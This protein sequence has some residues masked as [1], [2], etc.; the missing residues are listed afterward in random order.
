MSDEAQ[1]PP[2]PTPDEVEAD[3]LLQR[4]LAMSPSDAVSVLSY[5]F[6]RRDQDRRY[7][8]LRALI[9]YATE[10]AYEDGYDDGFAE[11]GAAAGEP[12]DEREV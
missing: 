11:G 5:L 6:R 8:E 7:P 12:W 4:F 1:G 10:Q 9:I 3:R 2:A